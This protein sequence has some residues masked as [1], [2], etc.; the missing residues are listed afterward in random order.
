LDAADL[1]LA[2]LSWAN[3]IGADRRRAD[4]SDAKGLTDEQLDQV[5]S[6][7]GATMSDGQKYEDWRK[8]GESRK[9]E[10]ENA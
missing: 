10:R 7:E 9:E 3:L 5:N 8:G 6:L 1:S 2:S 4:L